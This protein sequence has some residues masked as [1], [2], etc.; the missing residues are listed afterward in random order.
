[1]TVLPT[2]PVLTVNRPARRRTLLARLHALLRAA[3]HP[4]AQATHDRQQVRA[5]LNAEA[6]R[7]ALLRAQLTGTPSG[8]RV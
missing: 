6:H 5:A 7:A 3:L 8:G 2:R 1:M 4:D